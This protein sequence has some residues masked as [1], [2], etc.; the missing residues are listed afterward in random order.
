MVHFG[1]SEAWKVDKEF[2]MLRWDRYGFHKNCDGTR[3]GELV[4]LHLV[5]STCHVVDSGV[6]GA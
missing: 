3:Y 6:S 1:A 4:F 2:F 5:G